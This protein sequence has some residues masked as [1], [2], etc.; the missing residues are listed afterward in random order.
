MP[1]NEVRS[2]HY[3]IVAPVDYTPQALRLASLL[4]TIRPYIS[5]GIGTPPRNIPIVLRTEN[6]LSNGYVS[7]APKRE[8]LYMIPP[9]ETYA[10]LWEKQLGVHE[11]RHVVQ[12][13]TLR[14]GLTRMASWLVGEAGIG[15]GLFAMPRWQMEG[16][17]TLAETRL[18]EYGRGLQ[19]EFTV[20]YRALLGDSVRRTFRRIDPWICGSYNVHYPDIYRFGYQVLSTLER[21][22]KS[23][24]AYGDVLRYSGR[25]PIFVFT[26]DIWLLRQEQTS[27][28]RLARK[29]FAELDSLWQPLSQVVENFS[30]TTPAPKKRQ[31]I[32][33]SYPMAGEN[34]AAIRTDW[35]RPTRLVVR[36]STG[37]EQ[38]VAPV[39]TLTSR[40][41]RRGNQVWWSE[42]RPH[43]VWEQ[44]SFS[45]IRHT[46][47]ATGKSKLYERKGRWFFVT[48]TPQGFAAVGYDKALRAYIQY[49][50]P[51]MR[52]AAAFEFSGNK[53][54]S[55]HGLA[56]DSLSG[57]LCYIA[58]D[59]RG[60]HLGAVEQGSARALT[61]PSVVSLSGLSAGGGKLYFSSIASGKNEI[62]TLDLSNLV[63]RRISTSRY[64]STNPSAFGDRVV[65][66]TARGRGKALAA[67]DTAQCDTLPRVLWSRLPTNLVNRPTKPW[68]APAVDTLS[69]TADTT[70]SVRRYRR[71]GHMPNVHSW[72]PIGL[73]PTDGNREMPTT[74][75]VTAL[76]QSV[77]GDFEG[78]V[79][80]GFYT[81]R[82]WGAAS[83]S[84]KGLPVIFSGGVQYGGGVRDVIGGP[85]KAVEADRSPYG[86]AWLTASMPLNLSSGAV[87]RSLNPYM[88]V[89]YQNALL[90]NG[91]SYDQGGYA[92]YSAGIGYSSA[93][94]RSHR[95]IGTRLGYAVSLF[96]SGAFD[97]RFAMQGGLSATGYLPGVALNHALTVKVGAQYQRLSDLNFT[98]KIFGP[99]TAP[100]NYTYRPTTDYAAASV[101]YTAPIAYPD[102]GWEGVVYIRRIYGALFADYA[103]GSYV[104]VAPTPVRRDSYAVGATVGLNLNWLRSYDT[105]VSFTYAYPT[106][107]NV[108]YTIN[109]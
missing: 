66:A 91:S 20:G 9:E 29:T 74:I 79:S 105:S 43:P 51:Q 73:S 47:L 11:W 35:D 68:A 83:L 12:I 42:Y 101:T 1:L 102:W 90:W 4:D 38:R 61:R 18:A 104:G 22:A 16:D 88:S 87:S 72:A 94:R 44:E 56:Y 7:W 23:G 26:S 65:W 96:T 13:S 71:A 24:E 75:G 58:L 6:V 33:Y 106:Y 50:D 10:L 40:P 25:W 107:F 69:T 28:K 17:A 30:I 3:R 77:L 41:V 53:P 108:G 103:T 5:I 54:I 2:P 21:D 82:S 46:D 109:F 100:D 86:G 80:Y 89:R 31:Y 95:A 64:G 63:E 52:R 93:Q 45:A 62:H 49:F 99:R 27:I 84:Y 37:Q 48:P 76:M 98:S 8:E 85:A 32:S 92:T 70:R 81:A 39:G 59:E 34:L 14:R 36:D 78:S 67:T 15:L 60:M 19:P 97:A 57:L 55:L